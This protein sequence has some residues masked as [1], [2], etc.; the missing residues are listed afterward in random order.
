[1]STG[2]KEAAEFYD[3]IIARLAE[4]KEFDEETDKMLAAFASTN[5]LCK[6]GVK[7]AIDDRTK[8]LKDPGKFLLIENDSSK[9]FELF[10]YDP[11]G[12]LFE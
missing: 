5:N 11:N 12:N 9:A 2:T 10:N 7:R 8:Q 6:D 3:S 4:K 1:M